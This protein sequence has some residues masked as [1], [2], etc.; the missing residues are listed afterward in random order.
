MCAFRAALSSASL[1]GRSVERFV[2]PLAIFHRTYGYVHVEKK[3][4]S[5]PLGPGF[6]W[7]KSYLVRS[8]TAITYPLK[9]YQWLT[10]SVFIDG[11]PDAISSL[12]SA[13]DEVIEDFERR[14]TEFLAYQIRNPS[15]TKGLYDKTTVRGLLESCFASIWPLSENYR[16]MRNSHMTFSPD[17][18]CYW[19]RNGDNYVARCS[20]MYVMH[21][22]KALGLMCESDF[23][24]EG[25]E[26]KDYLPRHLSFFKSSFDQVLPFGGSRKH[27]SSSLAHTVFM[28]NESENRREYLYTQGLME[29]F[30]QLAAEAIQEGFKIDQDLSYPM[31]T[32][33]IITDGRDFTFMALQLNTLDLQKNSESS[34]HN[35]FY[36]GPTLR[37][38]NE[39][40]VG[41]G[42]VNFNRDC[43]RLIVNYLLHQPVRKR[44][45]EL[46]GGEDAIP[47]DK[48]SADGQLISP[49]TKEEED[50]T[51][52][53]LN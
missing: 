39:V 30:S 36:G 52:A 20:P 32:Q 12:H 48:V 2:F 19:R 18:E 13:E 26:E 49:K 38:Y 10:K 11:L 34:R 44:L 40:E 6:I 7:R 25:L 1:N 9:K 5:H 35:V 46:R 50:I 47:L 21:C 45:Q 27:S 14:V 33:G 28:F 24:G 41:G 17:V 22:N 42:V 23:T 3:V 8:T 51:Y 37:L 29:L 4:P 15:R 43:A 53:Q 31:V 16:H